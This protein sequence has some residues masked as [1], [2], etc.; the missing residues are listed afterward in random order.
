MFALLSPLSRLEAA[1][2]N[3]GERITAGDRIHWRQKKRQGD[4]RAEGEKPTPQPDPGTPNAQES[5]GILCKVPHTTQPIPRGQHVITV[6]HT[7]NSG[8]SEKD[9]FVS[10]VR[11]KNQTR[12]NVMIRKNFTYTH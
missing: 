2:G 3:S 10:W 9:E 5:G 6:M 11:K 8:P 1:K 12:M 7:D 4:K